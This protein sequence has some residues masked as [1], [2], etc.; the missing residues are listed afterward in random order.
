MGL[1]NHTLAGEATRVLIRRTIGPIGNLNG[2]F[3]FSVFRNN[4]LLAIELFFLHTT[5]LRIIA[6]VCLFFYFENA[7]L[8]LK[9][10]NVET[11]AAESYF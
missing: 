5:P 6:I 9:P 2:R 11:Q 10:R 1:E 8:T 4:L 3:F 7:N